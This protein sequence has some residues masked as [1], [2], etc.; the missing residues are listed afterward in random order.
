MTRVLWMHWPKICKA[1]WQCMITYVRKTGA[2]LESARRR[3]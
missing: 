3:G 1:K 2:L